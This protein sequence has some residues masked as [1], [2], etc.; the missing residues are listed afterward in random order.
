MK[1]LRI[2]TP[3]S[4]AN[5]GPGFDVFA[6]TLEEPFD[7]V[8]VE[9]QESERVKIELQVEGKYP[10]P[11][12]LSENVLTALLLNIMDE[13]D[14]K[15]NLKIRL[16]KNIPVG[17][18][19]GSSG[20][21]SVASVLIACN[22]FDLKLSQ[23]EI[24]H[25]AGEGEKMIAGSPHYDN[26]TASLL[27]GF[28]IV[29]SKDSEPIKLDLDNNL[30]LC[31][32]M[33][34][35]NLPLKKTE[36]ARK[37]LPQSVSLKQMC[38]NISKASRIVYAFISKDYSQLKSAINDEVI[39]IHRTKFIPAYEEVRN[40]AYE[41]GALG[42]CLSGAGPSILAITSKK[43][44][45]ELVLEAMLDTFNKAGIK[46]EGFITSVGNGSKVELLA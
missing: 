35:I 1:R 41:N 31:I 39:E 14:L 42:V 36:F 45:P 7:V 10:V 34:K 28:V 27:G 40:A 17:M 16:Q 6:I 24:I 21:S 11:R 5:L 37:I 4:S 29:P 3:A 9:Y 33:P 2:I 43:A 15:G 26:V 20:A 25:L 46:A 22:I 8:E 18:G 23:K 19:L 13:H 44:N 12:T 38:E 32:A 30:R